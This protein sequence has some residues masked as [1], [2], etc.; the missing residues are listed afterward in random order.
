MSKTKPALHSACHHF[1]LLCRADRQPRFNHG[2]ITN[3]ISFFGIDMVQDEWGAIRVVGVNPRS[4]AASKIQLRDILLAIDL[5]SVRGLDLSAIIPL[6]E[7]PPNSAVS[8]R[9]FRDADDPNSRSASPNSSRPV[10]VCLVRPATATRSAGNHPDGP[11]IPGRPGSARDS[12]QPVKLES[13]RAGVPPAAPSDLR[14]HGPGRKSG[15]AATGGEPVERWLTLD[16]AV[17]PPPPP[18]PAARG[19]QSGSPRPASS[20]R[21]DDSD[22]PWD[23]LAGLGRP[24]VRAGRAIAAGDRDSDVGTTPTRSGTV[25]VGPQRPLDPCVPEIR[26][27]AEGTGSR[28][29]AARLRAA[30]GDGMLRHSDSELPSKDHVGGHGWGYGVPERRGRAREYLPAGWAAWASSGVDRSGDGERRPLAGS[31]ARP[32]AGADAG[33][34]GGEDWGALRRQMKAMIDGVQSL[35]ARAD[36]GG[37]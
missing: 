10:F 22:G 23:L 37:A 19:S 12:E 4:P 7:G 32:G 16:L 3:R 2:T 5:H 14:S 24:D 8:L 20:P 29:S 9:F 33:D 30:S 18:P 17:A 15:A 34:D 6:L 28:D 27:P 11:A 25:R 35:A 36:A 31:L 13:R 1:N 21:Q 26:G